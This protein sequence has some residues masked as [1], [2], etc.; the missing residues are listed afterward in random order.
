MSPNSPKLPQFSIELPVIPVYVMNDDFFP[1]FGAL[2]GLTKVDLP[3]TYV[4]TGL[5]YVKLL[6]GGTF[7]AGRVCPQANNWHITVWW[8]QKRYTWREHRWMAFMC[9]AYKH[10]TDRVCF[11]IDEVDDVRRRD[12]HTLGAPP[13]ICS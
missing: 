8:Y 5:G 1:G 4:R 7:P 3:S 9:A 13:R 12:F 2:A 11:F 6:P 10:Y